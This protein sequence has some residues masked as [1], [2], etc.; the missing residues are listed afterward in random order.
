MTSTRKSSPTGED[1]FLPPPTSIPPGRQQ[2]NRQCRLS[3]LEGPSGVG[4]DELPAF[5][6]S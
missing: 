1:F 6:L 3:F 2:V 4:V 5:L